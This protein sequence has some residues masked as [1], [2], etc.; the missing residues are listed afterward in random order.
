MD[1]PTELLISIN[2]FEGPLDLLLHLIKETKMDIQEVPM[3]TIVDQYLTFI[4]SMQTMQ[5]DVAGDYLVMAATLLEIKSRM[6]LPRVES[7][8]MDDDE[9]EDDKDLHA[10]LIQQLIEY[11][12]FK[13]IAT[14]LKD[15]EEERGAYFAKDP[16]N[17]DDYQETIPLSD[18]E[19]SIDDM[20]KA[21]QKMFQ[22]Q[23]AQKPIQA[24]LDVDAISVEDSMIAIIDRLKVKTSGLAL[25]EFVSSK[26]S[27]IATFLAMLELAKSKRVR[28]EQ[29]ALSSMIY[30]YPAEDLLVESAISVTSGN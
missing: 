2:D 11:Q 1:K 6:L 3:L 14:I 8:E 10:A 20:L 24:K 16:S 13:E 27:L 4:R 29:D 19:V 21:F 26:S 15:K 12:Q 17:L 9:Y 5:L 30:L 25:S 22:K 18:G 23:L 28:F 7:V